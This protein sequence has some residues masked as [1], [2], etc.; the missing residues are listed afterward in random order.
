MEL[1]HQE[2]QGFFFCNNFDMA[3]S[4]E[5]Y[6]LLIKEFSRY[7]LIPSVGHEFNI[8]TG[9]KTQFVT[10]VNSKDDLRV[11]F[12][13]HG[14]VVTQL[15]TEFEKFYTDFK[16]IINSLALLFPLKKGNRISLLSSKIFD[17]T[18]EQYKEIYLNLFT[19][20]AVNP[21]EWD[22]RIAEKRY[23]LNRSE[24]VNSISNIKRGEM[25]S[26]FFNNGQPKSVVAFSVDTNTSPTN[27]KDRFSFENSIEAYNEIYTNNL[28][29]LQ[30]LS[31]YEN[32]R[33]Y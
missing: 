22:N 27:A 8:H 32:I 30:E 26:P 31:R 2:H 23:I 13:S 6:N 15:K 24:E 12:P 16:N 21:F 1:I 29:L 3:P 14:I 18:E 5:L 20:K 25:V 7:D 28:R 17:G 19:Y 9:Q 10:L 4:P 33:K 11:E